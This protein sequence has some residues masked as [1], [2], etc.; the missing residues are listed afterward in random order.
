MLSE[1]WAEESVSWGNFKHHTSTREK[2]THTISI[3]TSRRESTDRKPPA[4]VLLG[5]Q[6]LTLKP[7]S[8]YC[9]AEG[10]F[11]YGFTLMP[12]MIHEGVWGPRICDPI[13]HLVLTQGGLQRE[14]VG[15]MVAA[16]LT[17]SWPLLLRN[18]EVGVQG[19]WAGIRMQQCAKGFMRHSSRSIRFEKQCISVP[20]LNTQSTRDIP[21]L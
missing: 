6:L 21:S 13:K 9:S 7:A 14:A 5:V 3:T 2:R 19:S 15:D 1:I 16:L 18:W 12:C 10:V 4:L 20:C 11:V 17:D 8:T